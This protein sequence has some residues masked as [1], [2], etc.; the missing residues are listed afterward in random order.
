M[1][2]S[3]PGA[4]D[5]PPRLPYGYVNSSSVPSNNIAYDTVPQASQLTTQGSLDNSP[6]GNE[7]NSTLRVKIADDYKIAPPVCSWTVP[8]LMRVLYVLLVAMHA[9]QGSH[10]SAIAT[11]VQRQFCSACASALAYT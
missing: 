3:L 9:S 1:Y 11:A 5:P 4:N 2:P 7:T 6:W 8:G 10:Q